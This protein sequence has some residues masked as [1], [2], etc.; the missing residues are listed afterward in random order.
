MR[1]PF[2]D[3]ATVSAATRAQMEKLPK[4][5]IFR[6]LT[7]TEVLMKPFLD[8]GTAALFKT[9]MDPILREMAIVRVGHLS[10]ATYE[11]YQHE[12]ISRDL[13]MAEDKVQGLK[14]G[15]GDPAFTP[16]EA[17][18]LRF[19][20]EVVLNVKASDQTWAELAQH[21]SHEEMAELVITIG[22]Y[23]AVS[24]FLENFEVQIEADGAPGPQVVR[25]LRD[26]AREGA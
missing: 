16:L 15:A 22:Y 11:V 23:M 25:T 21:L 7:H 5:N 6:Q 3:P 4:L 17:L 1:V 12:R 13:G 8:L 18:V 2:R 9:K 19:T 10:R 24:R 26:A 20:D 14:V